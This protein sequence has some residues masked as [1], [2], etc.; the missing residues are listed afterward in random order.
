VPH[1][2]PRPIGL[3]DY[4]A[5]NILQADK[6]IKVQK[7]FNGSIVPQKSKSDL[8]LRIENALLTNHIAEAISDIKKIKRILI[9]D[10]A[11][12]SCATVHAIA[13]KLKEMNPKLEICAI[14]QVCS[15]KGFD[16]VKDI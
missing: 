6:K 16:V 9:L 1:S 13:F 3:Q 11:I 5:E 14:A 2:L 15:Y 7:I 10:D 4:L 12:G 8:K